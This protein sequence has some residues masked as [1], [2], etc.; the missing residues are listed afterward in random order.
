MVI[1]SGRSVEIAS[2]F[3]KEVEKYFSKPVKYLFLTHTH[4]DHRNGMEAYKDINL[5]M[6]SK[7]VKNLPST[8]RI[9]KFIIIE[10]QKEYTI[11]D[12]D[13]KIELFHIGGHTIGSSCLYYQNEKTLFSGD[14]LFLGDVN[15]N[16]PFLGFYQNKP[17]LTGNPDESIEALRFFLNLDLETL[18]PGHGAVQKNPKNTIEKQLNFLLVLKRH[19]IDKIVNNIP[20]SECNLPKTDLIQQAFDRIDSFP[21]KE[22]NREKKWLENYLNWLRKSFYNYYAKF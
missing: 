7:L 3:R 10:F 4:S 13:Q 1:D 14:V 11:E 19:F 9:N 22:Q 16:I 21:I 8:V 15:Y 17:K 20:L 18:I 2:K 5:I 6:S 12:N